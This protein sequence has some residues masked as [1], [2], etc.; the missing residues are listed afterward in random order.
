VGRVAIPLLTRLR[1]DHY[2][3]K[4]A[5]LD[6]LRVMLLTTT[7]GILITMTMARPLTLF[8]LGPQ[9]DGVAPV[10]AWLC[11]GSLVSPIYA[12]QFWLFTTQDW[13]HRQMVYV[14][15]TSMISVIAFTA[16]LPWGP[17][18]AAAGVALSYVLIST[19]L[20][21]WGATKDGMVTP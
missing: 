14:A 9:W 11:L 8:L 1:P 2:R 5:Y 7:P 17:V 15:A 10:F 16:G 18:G 12:S 13:S 21:F 20:V 19:P 6:M 3:Y 4:S